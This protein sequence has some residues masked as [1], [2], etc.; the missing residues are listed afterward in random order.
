MMHN[1]LLQNLH[2]KL[3]F[4]R[5]LFNKKITFYVDIYSVVNFEVQSF[6]KKN[7]VSIL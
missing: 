3:Y 6:S 2:F 7:Y 1:E 5:I 4:S